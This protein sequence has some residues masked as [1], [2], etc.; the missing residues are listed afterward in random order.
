[1]LRVVPY[2]GTMSGGTKGDT[3]S[4]S[5]NRAVALVLAAFASLVAPARSAF[6]DVE[7]MTP[8]T[9]TV[10]GGQVIGAGHMVIGAS[11]GYPGIRGRFIFGLGNSFDLSIDP[12]ITY[13]NGWLSG[14][15]QGFGTQLEVP[16]RIQLVT[17]SRFAMALR[18]V[19][20][21]RIGR[22]APSWGTGGTIGVRASIPLPKLFSIVVGLD[23]RAG[24]GSFHARG[25]DSSGGVECNDSFFEGATYVN[26]GLE[27]YFRQKWYFYASHDVGVAYTSGGAYG[28]GDVCVDAGG[29]PYACGSNAHAYFH[30][31]LGFGYQMR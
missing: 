8:Q 5:A 10:V 27:T 21:F 25:C 19:P 24:L 26:F 7:T 12:Q 18:L 14:L 30:A 4:R 17:A 22:A 28:Y 23:T 29:N 15:N 9:P 13:A 11:S 20:Y 16:M 31:Q 1:M 6:A 2:A 3:M